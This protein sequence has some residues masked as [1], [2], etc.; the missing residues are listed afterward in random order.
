MNNTHDL[1]DTDKIYTETVNLLFRPRQDSL[2][3]TNNV[4]GMQRIIRSIHVLEN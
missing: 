4:T 1:H 2:A 3:H